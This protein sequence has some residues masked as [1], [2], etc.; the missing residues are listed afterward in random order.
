MIVCP[1]CG[2]KQADGDKCQKCASLF[3]YYRSQA[4]P[5][6]A[7][8]STEPS[9]GKPALS[10]ARRVYRI[11]TWASLAILVVAVLMI[12]RKSSAPQIPANPQAAR[13]VE[14]KLAASETSA[15]AGQSQPLRLDQDEV[16]AFLS[17]NLAL[18]PPAG[19]TS[20]AQRAGAAPADPSLEEVQSSVKDVKVTMEE[21]RVQGYVVFNLHGVDLS[22]DL[23]GRLHAEDGYLRFEP[24]GG[25]LGSLPIPQSTLETAVKRLLDSPENKEKLRL[26]DNVRDIRVENGE[27]VIIYR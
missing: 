7:I 4:A 10:W 20:P 15:A 13:R 22:L 8:A 16:N 1:N 3:D 25:K 2:Y 5:T 18:Q 19:R 23:E 12:L 11:T 27:L 24:T 9:R 21:D 17:S 6:S 14:E 26:P